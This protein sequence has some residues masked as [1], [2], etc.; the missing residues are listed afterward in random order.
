MLY[1]PL[2]FA[3]AKDALTRPGPGNLSRIN[4]TAECQKIVPDGL[5]LVDILANEVCK[6]CALS[7]SL[8]LS[9]CLPPSGRSL[10]FV[11]PPPPPQ[12]HEAEKDRIITYNK[13]EPS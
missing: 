5:G 7:L 10:E 13:N 3:L 9:P 1:N 12:E 11:E 2:A 8:S 6:C 4:V